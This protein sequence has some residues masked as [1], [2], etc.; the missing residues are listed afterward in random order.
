MFTRS[1]LESQ[2]VIGLREI[3]RNNSCPFNKKEEIINFLMADSEDNS[4][5]ALKTATAFFGQGLNEVLQSIRPTREELLTLIKE[6][7]EGD[8]NQG[9]RANVNVRFPS[10]PL[11][12][13]DTNGSYV[14]PPQFDKIE[15]SIEDGH[16]EIKGPPGSGKS[17]LIQKLAEKHNKKLAVIVAEAGLRKRDL[18]GG[19]ELEDATSFYQ[20][21]EFAAACV[22]GQWAVIEEL[23]F[24]E[25]DAIGFLLGILDRPGTKGSTFTLGG[26][27]FDVHP[28]FRCFITRNV[29]LAGTKKLNE[30]LVDRTNTFELPPLL[31]EDLDEM[32]IAHKVS[33]NFRDQSVPLIGTLYKAWQDSQIVYQISPRRVLQ[34]TKLAD[35]LGVFDYKQFRELLTEGILNKIDDLHDRIAVKGRIETQWDTLDSLDRYQS[36]QS[37]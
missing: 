12:R 2:G 9:V 15:A 6:A 31:G 14:I 32:L 21:A 20:A 27:S 8:T 19:G 33:K 30:A 1:E 18:I 3:A 10:V 29:N 13:P 23:S 5:H 36:E 24:S 4:V 28:D 7:F 35:R 11:S 16:V 22:S 17:L 34:A 37:R 25:P 26:K